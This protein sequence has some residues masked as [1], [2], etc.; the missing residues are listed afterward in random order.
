MAGGQVVELWTA[1][2]VEARL[3]EAAETLRRMRMHGIWPAT[4]R[5]AWPEM[6]RDYWD[7]WRFGRIEEDR[8]PLP[9]PGAID[10]MDKT[11][12]WVA[13]FVREPHKRR[14]LW[15][16][17]SRLSWRRIARMVGA[18]HETARFWHLAAIR[19]IVDGLNA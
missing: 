11:L 2:E 6:L 19:E 17:A 12:A 3:E 16:R 7:V 1:G 8:P 18:S 14:V 15:C 5:S 13:A 9:S 4:Y 10:R